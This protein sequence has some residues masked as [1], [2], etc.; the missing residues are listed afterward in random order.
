MSD[1]DLIR[2]FIVFLGMKGYVIVN[3]HG[4]VGMDDRYSGNP[5]ELVE[6]FFKEIG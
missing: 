4:I 2:R 1:L 3:V 6:Q 5:K